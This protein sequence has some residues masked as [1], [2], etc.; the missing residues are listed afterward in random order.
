ME[1]NQDRD[2]VDSDQKTDI[3]R[4][5]NQDPG[6]IVQDRCSSGIKEENQE[7]CFFPHER[8]V[9]EENQDLDFIKSEVKD[10]NLDSD[11]ID[12]DLDTS[13]VKEEPQDPDYIQ[14]SHF[15]VEIKTE[16]PDLLDENGAE[17]VPFEQRNPTSFTEEESRDP[18]CGP[19][20]Q[21]VCE[22]QIFTI[23]P[24]QNI[25]QPQSAPLYNVSNINKELHAKGPSAKCTKIHKCKLLHIII[26]I[27]KI[28]NSMIQ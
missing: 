3:M 14:H 22:S 4:T 26:I 5:Q 21:Q 28:I 12:Q 27:T 6:F 25:I 10:E 16:I 15:K 13:R 24:H 9:K 17:N 18:S 11:R 1:D 2:T 23:T 20:E 7:A 8:G 19:T